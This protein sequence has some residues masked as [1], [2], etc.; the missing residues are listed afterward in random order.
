[1][2]IFYLYLFLPILFIL[3]EVFIGEKNKN[4]LSILTTILSVIM[5]ILTILLYTKALNQTITLNSEGP[6]LISFK[7]DLLSIIT[8]LFACLLWILSSTYSISYF[9]GET[10][11]KLK[12]YNIFSI[13]NLYT[14]LLIFLSSNMMTFFI[15]FELLLIASYVLIIHNQTMESFTAGI[16]YLFFQIIGGLLILFAIILTYSIAKTTNFTPGGLNVLTESK[17]FSIIFWCY[18]IG[19]SIKAGLFPVHI[20]LPEAHPVAPSPASALLSGMVIKTGAI[21]IMRLFLQIFGVQNLV[22]KLDVKILLILALFTMFWG[23]A[24]AIGETHLKR[25][26]AYSSVSQIGYIIMGISLLSPLGLLGALMHTLAHSVVKGVLFMSAGTIIKETGSTEVTKL[27]GYGLKNPVIFT[28]FT[29]GAL[30]MIGFPLFVNFITKWTLGVSALEAMNAGIIPPYLM[31]LSIAILLI[32][33]ILNAIY[34]APIVIRGWFYGE[35]KEKNKIM[36]LEAI[37]IIIG[38]ILIIL[39]G[40]A[41][42]WLIDISGKALA[43]LIPVI[44]YPKPF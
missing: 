24:V 42:A 2:N 44:V 43:P 40:I 39:F 9:K 19:F 8:S 6:I 5:L 33:S 18:V 12:R 17:F 1:M 4:L 3:I 15:F 21:G 22:G 25:V 16:K 20:W 28:G 37:P 34:Y 11:P 7:V 29:V 26:L 41:P 27:D 23:S 38:T 32:S 14:I 13:L 35:A 30:S 10:F 31:I 36:W